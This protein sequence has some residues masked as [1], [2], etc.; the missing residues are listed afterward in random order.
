M[1]NVALCS[2]LFFLDSRSRI[3]LGNPI[4]TE[5]D[6]QCNYDRDAQKYASVEAQSHINEYGIHLA[7]LFGQC[8]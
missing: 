4:D 1:N 8:R 3:D 7:E 6:R 2:V 5:T